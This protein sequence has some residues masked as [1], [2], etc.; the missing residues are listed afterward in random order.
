MSASIK[1]ISYYLPGPVYS[2][3][4]FFKEFPDSKSANLE[5]IGIKERRIVG[6]EQ[7]ASD[8]AFEAAEKLFSEHNID[9]SE[10]DFLIISILEQDYYAPSS[11]CVLHGK[12][13]LK[14]ECGALDF[15]LACSAYVY[16]LGLAAGV[17]HSMG[18]KNVL[19]LTT[20]VLSHK[21]HPKDKSARFVFGDAASATLL[22]ASPSEKIGPFVYGTDGKGFD[23]IYIPHGGTQTP[24]SGTSFT[25]IK[26]EFGNVTSN[27]H[28]NMDG[29]GVF[30]F[31]IRTVPP[32]IEELLAK[33]KLTPNDIDL[34]IFHQAN[35]FINETLRKKMGIPEEK[36]V[37]SMDK[38]GNTVQATIPIAIYESMR[39]GRLKPGMKV[40]LAGF[41]SGLSW[42]S[43]IVQF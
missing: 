26:D 22:T 24:V 3:D 33:A 19:F 10:I 4:D 13:G 14:K 16:G 12:L 9:R 32:M 18:A 42:A 35:A 41:G 29:M 38:T 1:A 31:T 5:K 34:Y 43:T 2:N 39:T 11:A 36:F 7:T 6:P 17:M 37:H 21:I 27:A 15:T 8:L 28:L 23:K 30:L 40:V 20:S 25:D